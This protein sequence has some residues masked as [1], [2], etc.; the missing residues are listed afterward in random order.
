V[1]VFGSQATG[2]L[3]PTSDIDIVID[4]KEGVVAME[5]KDD[6]TQTRGRIGTRTT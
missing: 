2:L 3:L 6:N 4:L 1:T 5:T